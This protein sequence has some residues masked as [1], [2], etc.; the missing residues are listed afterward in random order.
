MMTGN[1]LTVSHPSNTAL[2][3]SNLTGNA[4]LICVHIVSGFDVWISQRF[5]VLLHF[6]QFTHTTRNNSIYRCEISDPVTTGLPLVAE[7]SM[8]LSVV[9]SLYRELLAAMFVTEE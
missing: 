9:S 4:F 6:S 7:F 2:R 8:Q 1:C 5:C 3:I